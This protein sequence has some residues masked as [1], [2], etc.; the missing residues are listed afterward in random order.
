MTARL[1]LRLW[2]PDLPGRLAAVAQGIAEAGGNVLGLEVLERS[3]GVA[4]DELMVEVES[5]DHIDAMCRA[6]QVI[7]G[8]GVEEVRQVPADAEE[9]GL[10]VIS[11][12][13]TILETAN[14]TATLSAL[15]GLVGELFDADW[16]ALVDL[17]SRICVESVG[18]VPPVDWL[19][20]FCEGAG[21][22][23]GRTSGSGVMA[24]TLTEANLAIC[25]GRPFGFRRREQRELDMLARVADRM[26][27]PLRVDRIPQGWSSNGRW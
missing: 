11:A 10:Q 27:R 2:L 16:T 8:A 17:A 6:I 23:A 5:P 15:S 13:V 21:A 4:V 25:V 1:A 26:C 3:D 9:R 18:E 19:V 20:A 7:E 12:A 24:G 14:P 22:A